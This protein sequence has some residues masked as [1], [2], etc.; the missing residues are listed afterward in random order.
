MAK[1]FGR[2]AVLPPRLFVYA[3]TRAHAHTHA[4]APRPWLH[5]M[6]IGNSISAQQIDVLGHKFAGLEGLVQNLTIGTSRR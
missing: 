2:T 1:P 6:H 5:Q 4:H 3:H